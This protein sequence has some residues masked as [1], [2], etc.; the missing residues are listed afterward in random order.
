MT[1]AKFLLPK[2]FEGYKPNVTLALSAENFVV[3]T[4][5]TAEELLGAFRLRNSVFYE[6]WTGQS[7]QSGLDIDK[8]DVLSDHLIILR[9]DTNEVVG[10][11]RLSS[12]KFNNR[13]YTGD[14]FGIDPFLKKSGHKV[15][16]GR[17]CT[18][19]SLRGSQAIHYMWL[20]LARY[21]LH[22]FSRYMF[23]CV[24]IVNTSLEYTACVYKTFLEMGAVD[25][26]CLVA[27]A[28]KYK[29][30]GFD[31]HLTR[32]HV[33]RKSLLKLPR[34]FLWYLNL[35]V[36]LHGPPVYDPVFGSY[37]FFISLDFTNIKNQKLVN[38]YKDAVALQDRLLRGQG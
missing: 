7:S 4:A 19:K 12:A 1:K 35:G 30:A 26:D 24:S 8:Y 37:D 5:E 36:K 23:G 21:F 14:F 9:K 28:K 2:E 10:A 31:E 6:E 16:M 38:R 25:G 15:E 13:F 22:T 34:L 20:G 17:A 27:P 29:I 33:D 32:A 11:Y 18:C 3:K